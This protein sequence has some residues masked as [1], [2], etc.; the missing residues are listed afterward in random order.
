M[1]NICEYC[2]KKGYTKEQYKQLKQDIQQ[3]A[4]QVYNRTEDTKGM[5]SPTYNILPDTSITVFIIQELKKLGMEF[6]EN[7]QYYRLQK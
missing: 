7:S 3:R 4:M 1:T 6:R 5:Y 2:Y